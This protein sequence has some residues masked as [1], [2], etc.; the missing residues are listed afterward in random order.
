MT[1]TL[2]VGAK[3][4]VTVLLDLDEQF[5]I[6]DGCRAVSATCV[7]VG[8]DRELTVTLVLEDPMRLELCRNA[9]PDPG[10]SLADYRAA[11]LEKGYVPLTNGQQ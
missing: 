3:V 9:G 4:Q 10:P 2:P 6:P 7:E 8:F 1:K 5:E 11:L